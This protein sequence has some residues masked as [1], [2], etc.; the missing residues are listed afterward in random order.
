MAMVNLASTY[1]KSGKMK[2][3]IFILE[4]VIEKS[5]S[6]LADHPFKGTKFC[7]IHLVEICLSIYEVFLFVHWITVKNSSRLFLMHNRFSR[8]NV[9]S[10]MHLWNE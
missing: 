9:Q 5:R 8:C 10:W 7:R 6:L 1:Q 3:A 2:E 4:Q